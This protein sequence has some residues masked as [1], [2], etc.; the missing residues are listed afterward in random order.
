[1]AHSWENYP[2]N[3]LYDEATWQPR[4]TEAFVKES[5]DRY[6]NL[7]D[8]Y[9]QPGPLGLSF[10]EFVQDYQQGRLGHMIF[11]ASWWGLN[12]DPRTSKVIGKNGWSTPYAGE[13]GQA[14]SHRGY[15][16]IGLNRKSQNAEATYK[17]AE[18]L[19]NKENYRKTAMNGILFSR[20]SLYADQELIAKYPYYA[21]QQQ[22]LDAIVKQRAYRPRLPE[23]VQLN[24]ILTTNLAAA[25]AKE[26]STKDATERMQSQSERLLKRWGYYTA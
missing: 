25:S 6:I 12:E 24:D 2:N 3:Q 16:L 13:R 20:K 14:A 22:N 10:N 26:I 19:S 21:Q 8:N 4:M 17:F 5:L 9:T 11:W 23:F 15:W 7:M 18:F 1:M